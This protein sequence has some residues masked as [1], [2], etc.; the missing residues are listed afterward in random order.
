MSTRVLVIDD[1]ANIREI[2]RIMLK[3]YEVIEASNGREAVI[4]YKNLKPDIVLMDISMP[5]MD[6]VEATREILKINPNAIVIGLTAFSRTR[7][8][9]LI[10]AGA[11]DIISK[12][13][14]RKSLKEMIEK[15]VAKSVT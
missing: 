10:N 11:K 5:E 4:L 3:D 2:V 13:F 1:D 12:P 8:N 6:G 15:F 9:E 14:T 7:G